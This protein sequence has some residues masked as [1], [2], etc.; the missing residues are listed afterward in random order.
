M[1]TVEKRPRAETSSK[2]IGELLDRQPPRSIEA[3][4]RSSAACFSCPKSVTK[5]PLSS[6]PMTSMTLPTVQSL[7]HMLALHEGG[8]QIDPTLLS[9]LLKDAGQYES[10]GGAA[11]LLELSQ[12]V[13]TAAH[14]E[15]YAR[16]IRDKAVLR[17]LIH[18]STDIIQESYET[19]TDARTMLSRARSA[20][21]ASSIQRA[22]RK[23]ASFVTYFT[24][25]LPA[26]MPACNINIRTAG[27]KP[28]SSISTS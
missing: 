6:V 23:F 21:S 9:Q 7:R 25:R 1:A 3:E 17:S 13:A 14:A 27:W 11:F 28:A 26:S 10:V 2:G 22:I 16:I 15:Y 8:R 20:C 12:E 5:L 4:R 24:N 18:A 19:G